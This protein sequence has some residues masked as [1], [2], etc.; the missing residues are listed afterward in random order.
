MCLASV[1]GVWSCI[2]RISRDLVGFHVLL[3]VF[4]H[5]RSMVIFIDDGSY[6]GVLFFGLSTTTSHMSTMTNFTNT[7]TS[8]F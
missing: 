8:L 4:S 5:F 3:C 6:S 2:R 7:P 1:E